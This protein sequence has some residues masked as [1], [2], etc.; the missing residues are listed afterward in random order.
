MKKNFTKLREIHEKTRKSPELNNNGDFEVNYHVTCSQIQNFQLQATAGEHIVKLD[1]PHNIAGDNTA[2]NAVQ[3]LI[4]AFAS[5]LE[6]N[7]LFYITAYK[8]EVKDV[9]VSV[10]ALI[11]RR[12]SLGLTPA[13]LKSMVITSKLI[14][15]ETREKIEHIGEKA[16]KTCVVGGSLHP[17][18][19]KIYK[20]EIFPPKSVNNN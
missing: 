19:E 13:R 9:S 16:K 14:S 5:C 7:W 12:Y 1:E 3:M 15:N 10:S 18:I 8:L 6:T 20:I 2:M 17:D 4:S 11:D